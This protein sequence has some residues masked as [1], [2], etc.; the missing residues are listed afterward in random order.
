MIHEFS[1]FL[2]LNTNT[3]ASELSGSIK[4]AFDYMMGMP[5]LLVE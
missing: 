1:F 2:F 3:D 5:A 4:D